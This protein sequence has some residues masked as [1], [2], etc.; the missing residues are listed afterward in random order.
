[1]G[2]PRP[3][4]APWAPGVPGVSRESVVD[5]P[6]P[7]PSPTRRGGSCGTPRP[8]RASWV[9]GVPGMSGERVGRLSVGCGWWEG[10]GPCSSAPPV[11][12]G[13]GQE[14]RGQAN[15]ALTRHI[16]VTRYPPLFRLPRLRSGTHGWV[17]GRASPY[18]QPHPTDRRPTLAFVVPG[19]TGTH[20][21]S[22]AGVPHLHPLHL[23]GA[24]FKPTLARA[25]R[26]KL[27][28]G[29]TGLVAGWPA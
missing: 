6:S 13:S 14:Q 27:K 9:P 23:A 10:G 16:G 25:R 1:M 29:P 22:A 11:G 21:G 20:G 2:E 26:G 7:Q 8:S 17:L 15:H 12:T 18:H 4:R 19:T 5:L 24:G 3:S 28:W